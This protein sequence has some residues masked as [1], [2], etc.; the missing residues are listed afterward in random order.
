VHHGHVHAVRDGGHCGLDGRGLRH[1]GKI[2][3]RPHPGGRGESSEDRL[4]L[5]LITALDVRLSYWRVFVAGCYCAR[6]WPGSALLCQGFP[7]RC[8]SKR[9]CSL[10]GVARASARLNMIT[11]AL[12][13]AHN[14]ALRP[15]EFVVHFHPLSERSRLLL[16]LLQTS[17]SHPCGRSCKPSRSVAETQLTSPQLFKS[18]RVLYLPSFTS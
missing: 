17:R 9:A 12:I 6:L 18:A 5:S 13:A 10:W 2:R 7:I 4:A 15:T 11:L 16:H 8:E 14:L 3:A 1:L